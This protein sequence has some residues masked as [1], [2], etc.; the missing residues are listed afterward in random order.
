[1]LDFSSE[2]SIHG[3]HGR[4]AGLARSSHPA[5]AIG[6]PRGL[7]GAARCCA[8]TIARGVFRCQRA[9]EHGPLR[10][11]RPRRS[12]QRRPAASP[13]LIVS[14]AIPNRIMFSACSEA[15]REY[16]RE[17]HASDRMAGALR[18][19]LLCRGGAQEA[20]SDFAVRE[21]RRRARL[22]HCWR[23]GGHEERCLFRH[24][25]MRRLF[26]TGSDRN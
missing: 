3:G 21:E 20:R 18:T 11:G 24:L 5:S 12:G 1:M 16:D 15:M 14:A 10:R 8:A 6:P 7:G 22:P 23:P 9:S 13:S 25:I 26:E 4:R 17:H 2:P 19:R